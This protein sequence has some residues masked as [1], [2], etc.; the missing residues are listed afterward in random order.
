MHSIVVREYSHT[1]IQ[2]FI[3]LGVSELALKANNASIAIG[4]NAV[5]RY[6]LY[7]RYPI[8]ARAW[9]KLTTFKQMYCVWHHCKSFVL[10]FCTTEVY[11]LGTYD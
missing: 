1:V 2:P 9:P 8:V 6:H 5:C 3:V 10:R 7:T 11:R 4:F